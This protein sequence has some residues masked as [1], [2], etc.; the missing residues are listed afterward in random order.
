ML[1]KIWLSLKIE[2]EGEMKYEGR[3]YTNHAD[4][5]EV[6]RVSAN[7]ALLWYCGML[8]LTE[9]TL[10]GALC[11]LCIVPICMKGSVRVPSSRKS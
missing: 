9:V 8:M 7:L 5:S 11:C 4:L 6:T 3:L 10:G 1:T 2:C